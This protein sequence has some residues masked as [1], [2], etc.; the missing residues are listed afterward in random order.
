MSNKKEKIVG[1]IY[2][3]TYV[4]NFHFHL[5][6]TTKYRHKLFTTGTLV[7]EMKEILI[8]IAKLNEITIEKME[9]MPDH[10]HLLI[11]F[12]P[13]LSATGAVKAIKGAS[14]RMFFEKHPEIKAQ[15]FWSGHLWTRSY[16]MSTLG[17]MSKEVVEQYIDDQYK[18]K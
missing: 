5:I 13:K 18:K 1:A 12:K 3:Q 15:K 9:V 14:A 7:Q 6:W 17:T 8:R 4:Y 2:T 10:V 11:S 16:Y